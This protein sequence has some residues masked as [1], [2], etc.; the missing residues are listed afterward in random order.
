MV[1][2]ELQP[3]GRAQQGKD[4]VTCFQKKTDTG[5]VLTLKRASVFQA[6]RTMIRDAWKTSGPHR[7]M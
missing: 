7:G 1:E 5:Q 4:E 2:L 6:C 3:P